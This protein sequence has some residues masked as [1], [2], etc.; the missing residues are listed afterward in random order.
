MRLMQEEI[1]GPVLPIVEYRNLD[2]AIQL[3]NQAERPLAL[4]WFGRSSANR[5]RVLQT[6][7]S[8]G[9]TVNDCLWHLA[10]ENQPFGGVGASGMGT[11]HGEWGFNTFSKHKPV[12]H[13]ARWNGTSLFRPPYGA[14]FDRL[15]ATLKR[16][17]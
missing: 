16:I 9:V 4:Y 15:L 2:E 13:Q 10:Q 6:T 12:F 3:I 8:G 5:D 7:H 11:Y 14:I 17:A 1:F